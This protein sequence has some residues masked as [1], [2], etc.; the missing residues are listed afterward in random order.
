MSTVVM[1]GQATIGREQRI[2]QA[3]TNQK[4]KERLFEAEGCPESCKCQLVQGRSIL[5]YD[6]VT[7]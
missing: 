5:A 1:L 3:V 4:E 7:S 2:L 6:G